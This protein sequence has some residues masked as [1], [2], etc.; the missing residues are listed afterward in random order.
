MT[1]ETLARSIEDFLAHAPNSVVVED[2]Q[3]VFDLG[4]AK[5]SITSEHQKCVLQLWSSERNSVRRVLDSELKNGVLRL[6][7]R[8]FGQSKPHRLEIV[9]ERDQRTPAAKKATR[10]AYLR[11]LER[12]LLR[13]FPDYSLYKGRLSSSIDLHHSFGPVHVRGLIRKG[14]SAFAAIG[15]NGEETTASIDA[16]LTSGLLWLHHCREQFADQ[17][18]VE[19]LKVFLPV[20]GS[21][22]VRARMAHLN[23]RAAKFHVYELNERD[24]TI[25]QFD[26]ADAGN[27]ATRLVHCPDNS[28]AEQRFSDS[29]SRIKALVPSTEVIITSATEVSFSLH[30][31]EFARARAGLTPGSFQQ[32]Q[33]IV[34]GAGRFEITLTQHNEPQF[35]DLMRRV[36]DSRR[37]GGNRNDPLWRMQPERW[38]ESELLRDITALDARLDPQA[39]YS[40]VPAFA[41]ADRAMIDVLART[42]DGRLAVLELKADEDLQLPMQ[43]LDYWSR[44]QWHQQRAEFRKFGYFPNKELSAEPPLLILVAPALH[45]H[46]ATDTLLKYISPKIEWEL[47]GVNE[48]WREGIK[49]IFRKSK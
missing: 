7:V 30:G 13:S 47:I 25:E 1:P 34:F 22:T 5:Y 14:R 37:P 20:G 3:V 32:T 18:V 49:V 39:I 6:S 15:V 44:V 43:G 36:M 21:V 40:Q 19:G 27:V 48:S 38:M 4:T 8:K 29:I 35:L 41:A 46:P 33:E 16:A 9:R 24:E 2:G 31:L 28:S 12:V 23:H 17:G 10:A 11:T 45:V 26:A 42:H